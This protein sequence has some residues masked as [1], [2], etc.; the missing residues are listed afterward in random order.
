MLEK[1]E[2]T[3]PQEDSPGWGEERQVRGPAA[4]RP[5]ESNA[6]EVGAGT[7][8]TRPQ[9]GWPKRPSYPLRP[10]AAEEVWDQGAR[11][12]GGRQSS[13]CKKPCAL[14]S[15][16]QQNFTKP[17]LFRFSEDKTG[18]STSPRVLLESIYP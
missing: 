15:A 13:K 1:Q 2:V 11:A 7:Q 14:S 10:G 4:H 12:T 6:G 16:C 5:L 8:V 17:C 3:E 9:A 18:Q